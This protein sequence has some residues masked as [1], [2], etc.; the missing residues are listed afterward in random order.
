[1][2][3]F[4]VKLFLFV[5]PFGILYVAIAI[6]NYTVDATCMFSR[7]HIIER[8]SD[9][10]LSGKIV[11]TPRNISHRLFQKKIIKKI[12]KVP[13]TIAI[14]SSRTITLRASYLGL[15]NES[16]FNHSVPDGVLNDLITI[17]GC[18]KEKGAFPKTI[19]IGI[20]P[21]MFDERFGTDGRWKFIA[22]SYYH[23][24]AYIRD[25]IPKLKLMYDLIKTQWE[26]KVLKMKWLLS[27]QHAI[28][29]YKYYH[30]VLKRGVD[31]MVVQDTSVD[32]WL[33][34]PDGSIYFPYSIRFRNE[35]VSFEK[36]LLIMRNRIKKYGEI[37]FKEDFINLID[38]LLS[39]DT[40]IIFFLSPYHPYVWQEI[41]KKGER[42]LIFDVEEMIRSVAQPRKIPII[43]TFNPHRFNF[44]NR[45]F[46]DAIH[47]HDHALVKIF[48]G[49]RNVSRQNR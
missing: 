3:K 15:D 42:H 1:M 23:L 39:T 7:A 48:K 43:G 19:I 22:S 40:H 49:Y 16:F 26:A 11:I 38:Y 12:K 13:S 24:L 21:A 10:V 34:T 29:N 20:D 9:D 6:F 46:W 30:N 32:D 27:Y 2:Q 45:D 14:G 5:L 4:I 35:A 37:T 8:A 18:Y 28:T 44:T 25:D 17:L 36:C 33:V 41:S 31:Y 47:I